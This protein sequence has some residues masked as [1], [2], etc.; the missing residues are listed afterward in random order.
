[1][2]EIDEKICL[3]EQDMNIDM[4]LAK[5]LSDKSQGYFILKMVLRV[6]RPNLQSR[7]A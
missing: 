7:S 3:L 2:Y 6:S 5:I 1:M 4:I